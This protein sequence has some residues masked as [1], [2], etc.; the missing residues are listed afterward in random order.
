MHKSRLRAKRR[1][2]ERFAAAA[3]ASYV[4]VAG[5]K[6]DMANNEVQS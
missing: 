5:V 3:P 4:N 6:H 1:C 2:L